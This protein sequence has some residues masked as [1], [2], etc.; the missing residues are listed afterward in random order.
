M[1]D[2]VRATDNGHFKEDIKE[3]KADIKEMK[4]ISIK[5]EKEHYR[6]GKDLYGNGK[7]GLIDEVCGHCKYIDNQKGSFGT[8]KF[9]L[10]FSIGQ[11][12]GIVALFLK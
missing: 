3:I 12:I 9:L 8:I 10:V 6:M 7:I 2:R 5:I 11:A 4:S 1:P